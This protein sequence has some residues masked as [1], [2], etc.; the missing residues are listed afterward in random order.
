MPV[1]CGDDCDLTFVPAQYYGPSSTDQSGAWPQASLQRQPA[2][3]MTKGFSP[4]PVPSRS[5]EQRWFPESSI[6]THVPQNEEA[7]R[8]MHSVD[9][10]VNSGSILHAASP[11]SSLAHTALRLEARPDRLSYHSPHCSCR[12]QRPCHLSKGPSRRAMYKVLKPPEREVVSGHK[13]SLY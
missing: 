1:A 4:L 9:N 10:R 2:S 6:R 8:H 5:T 12:R 7:Y 11:G 13:P 3:P